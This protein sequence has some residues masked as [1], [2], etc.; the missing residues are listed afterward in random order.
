MGVPFWSIVKGPK[1]EAG[2]FSFF[3][4]VSVNSLP[5]TA[6]QKKMHHTGRDTVELSRSALCLACL[7]AGEAGLPYIDDGSLVQLRSSI[8]YPVHDMFGCV[9]VC[10]RECVCV[11]V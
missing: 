5:F 10:V 4:Q 3:G 2:I 1:A 6:M 7:R 8:Y 11:C 9:C